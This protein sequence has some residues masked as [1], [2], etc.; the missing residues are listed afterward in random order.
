ML[1]ELER[2]KALSR[3]GR[4]GQ[5]LPAGRLHTARLR[6]DRSAGHDCRAAEPRAGPVARRPDW[7][8]S[9]RPEIVRAASALSDRANRIQSFTNAAPISTGPL[10]AAA[11]AASCPTLTALGVEK[12]AISQWDQ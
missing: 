7:L 9:G 1:L 10:R 2:S 5:A 6:R 11:Y 3:T 4:A 12:R 8:L